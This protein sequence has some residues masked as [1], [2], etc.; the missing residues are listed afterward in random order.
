MFELF[1]SL[2]IT[3]AAVVLVPFVVAIYKVYFS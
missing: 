3:A 1:S 2:P